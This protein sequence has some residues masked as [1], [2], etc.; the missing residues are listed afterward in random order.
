VTFALIGNS[1]TNK[2]LSAMYNADMKTPNG[3]GV[4]PLLIRD[5]QGATVFAGA[6]AWIQGFPKA[7]LGKKVGNK[8]WQIRVAKLEMV[9]G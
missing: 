5:T 7:T 3:M 4:G 8:E 1:P 6:Q 2:L 9:L